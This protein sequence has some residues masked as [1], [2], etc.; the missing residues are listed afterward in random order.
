MSEVVAM[1]GET[2]TVVQDTKVQESDAASAVAADWEAAWTVYLATGRTVA[3]AFDEDLNW[4]DTMPI[5]VADPEEATA[6]KVTTE[7]RVTNTA[8][9][10][11]D[12][13][14]ETADRQPTSGPPE[15]TPIVTAT[16][17]TQETAAI[18]INQDG[19]TSVQKLAQSFQTLAVQSTGQ[20][21]TSNNHTGQDHAVDVIP[22]EAQ[23]IPPFMFKVEKSKQG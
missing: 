6:Q 10:N 22:E 21:H 4:P 17:P 5:S 16:A 14:L 8:P 3:S 23:K 1:N 13:A 12:E 9:A 20:K 11:A 18:N 19:K 7:D 15:E 2:R